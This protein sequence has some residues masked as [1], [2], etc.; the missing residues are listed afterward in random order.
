MIISGIPVNI[1]KKNI[2]HMHLSVLP[3]NG[4][5]RVSA[6]VSTTD[7]AIRLFVISKLD[8]VK[9]QVKSFDNQPRQTERE[10]ITGETHFLWGKKYRL[11]VIK[12]SKNNFVDVVGDKILM[13]IHNNTTTEN[14]VKLMNEW[15]REQ[16]ETKLPKYISKWEK[17]IGV[18]TESVKIRNMLTKWGS[19]NISKKRILI[20]L[21]LAKKPVHCL[22][23]VIV[24]EL[25]HLVEKNHTDR[26]MLLMDKFLPNWQMIK[27]DLNMTPLDFMDKH[28]I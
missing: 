15:H 18:K 26:F 14:R 24:H 8:W 5:V 28:I 17:K 27:E 2:K 25:I 23:Y 12:G 22:E 3:P 20:N 13:H 7:D 19:C 16:L 1:I 21:Q 6:P 9:E 10:Y 4:A 11:K